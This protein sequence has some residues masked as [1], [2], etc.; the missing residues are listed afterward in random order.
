MI[1][2][3][4][5]VDKMIFVFKSYQNPAES[6]EKE[7]NR[8]ENLIKAN[9]SAYHDVIG[10]HCDIKFKETENILFSRGFVVSRYYR[11]WN[12]FVSWGKVLQGKSKSSGLTA[13]K[14][15]LISAETKNRFLIPAINAEEEI[16][17]INR[18]IESTIECNDGA[19]AIRYS[20]MF[21]NSIDSL[22]SRG[23][24]VYETSDELRK[25]DPRT[26]WI[27]WLRNE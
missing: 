25:S 16:E 15:R 7:I 13:K 27:H 6:K 23:F 22:V 8:I 17:E 5:A 4:E 11:T 24:T 18:V 19:G 1:T 14:V 2:S 12:S 20:I 21:Q 9:A 26:H 10:V 3:K